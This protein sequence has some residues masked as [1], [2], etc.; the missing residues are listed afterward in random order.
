MLKSTR[1]M[2]FWKTQWIEL[3]RIVGRSS[4]QHTWE[5]VKGFQFGD[6]NAVSALA[7]MR[8]A[9]TGQ[10]LLEIIRERSPG[11]GPMGMPDYLAGEWLHRHWKHV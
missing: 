1:G 6:S 4:A 11:S 9:G 10:S 7:E 5:L 3:V 2:L 8:Y